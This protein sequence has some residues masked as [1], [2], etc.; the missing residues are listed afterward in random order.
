MGILAT[1]AEVWSIIGTSIVTVV[2]FVP[3]LV[4][5]WYVLEGWIGDGDSYAGV[6]AS[7]EKRQ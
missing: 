6:T 5:A 2:L 7:I 1:S 4:Y 3:G